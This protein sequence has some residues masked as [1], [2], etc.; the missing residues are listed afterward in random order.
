MM[1]VLFDEWHGQT[2]WGE[3]GYPPLQI[4]T[5]FAGVV[6]C[7]N[8]K[9]YRCSALKGPMVAQNI[10]NASAVVI[11]SPV[12]RFNPVTSE[13]DPDKTSLLTGEEIAGVLSYL[14]K[15]GRLLAFSYR[16]GDAFTKANLGVLFAALGWYQYDDAV[17]NLGK[18]GKVHPLHTTFETRES[19][20][21]QK[22]AFQGVDTVAWRPVTSLSLLPNGIGFPVVH[23][24]ESCVRIGLVDH[25]ISHSSGAIC[26]A[27]HFGLG[28]YLLFGGPHAFETESLGFLRSAS[29]SRFLINVLDWLFSAQEPLPE[30]AGTRERSLKSSPGSNILSREQLRVLWNRA[31]SASTT[32]EKGECLV[33]FVQKFLANS[34]IFKPLVR[35]SWSI[36]REAEIDLVFECTSSKPLW[37]ACR[38]LVP[39]EC[40]NWMNTV[41]SPEIS[42]F[43]E[44]VD[45]TSSKIGL[46]AARKYS[47]AA[48]SAV[49]KSRLLRSTV[50]GL[51]DESDFESYLTGEA[52]AV[53]VVEASIVRSVLT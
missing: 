29:N 12:G 36:D 39:V 4:N 44:K 9:G 1:E 22:W 3:T 43:A 6:N 24:P 47:E 51:L 7:L 32:K 42:R 25:S 45:R 34:G 23:S 15:G 14:E 46:F 5:T 52:E 10:E 19:E 26:G 16:F 18:F 38:G 8:Q 28:K 40:K 35:S 50:I 41:G 33:D 27:G 20:F 13:W 48:W 49:S 2:N 17:I 21:D 11:P 53:D 31:S 37:S 30:G